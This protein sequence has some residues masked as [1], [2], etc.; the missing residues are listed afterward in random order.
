VA[1]HLIAVGV[2]GTRP[3]QAGSSRGH[4][5]PSSAA[6]VECGTSITGWGCW[7]SDGLGDLVPYC[8]EC[9]QREFGADRASAE[10]RIA[11]A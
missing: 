4:A 2:T 3:L 6:C 10:R 8:T 7:Y 11:A 1:A 9:A 5:A